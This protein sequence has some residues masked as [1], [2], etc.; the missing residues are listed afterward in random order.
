MGVLTTRRV[1]GLEA[2][3]TFKEY[4]DQRKAG[5]DPEGDFVRVARADP[6]LRDASSWAE[7]K[8]CLQARQVSFHVMDAGQLA[9]RNYQKTLSTANKAKANAP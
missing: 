1:S 9:W 3:M 7:L 8:S 4:L 2:T 5:Y 6:Q